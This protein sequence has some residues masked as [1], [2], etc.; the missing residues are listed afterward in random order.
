MR[1]LDR[2]LLDSYLGDHLAGAEGGSARFG[3]MA[4]AYADSPLGPALARI[5]QEV[6]DERDWLHDTA[7]R[8]GVRPSV[9]KRVGLAAVERV[10]RLKP[11]GRLTDPSPLTAVLEI[12]LMRGAVIAKRGLWETLHIWADDLGLDPAQLQRLLDQADEQ[13]ATLTRLGQV[14]REQ[15]FA[16]DGEP[17]RPAEE[18]R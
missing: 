11:N 2:T 17:G 6:T 13:I 18:A 3:R 9:V 1:R 16:E 12:D 15:A 8:L 7:H 5:A 14:A 4:E 10:G